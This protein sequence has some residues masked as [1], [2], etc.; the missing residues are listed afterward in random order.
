MESLNQRHLGRRGA[1]GD[2]RGQEPHVIQ[3]VLAERIKF[4][5]RQDQIMRVPSTPRD[6]F[7]LLGNGG[8]RPWVVPGDHADSDPSRLAREDGATGLCVCV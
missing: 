8:G 6:D 2:G 5:R 4:S 3:L 7:H 1:T